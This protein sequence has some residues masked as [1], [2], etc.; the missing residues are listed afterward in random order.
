MPICPECSHVGKGKYASSDDFR[1]PLAGFL[2]GLAFFWISTD[3]LSLNQMDFGTVFDLTG[4]VVFI[5]CG[6]YFLVSNYLK[7]RDLCP[8]C[9]YGHLIE[10]N[11]TGSQQVIQDKS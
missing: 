4:F 2:I 6:A 3:T 8:K 11:P 1:I 9:G 7:N 5:I 10:S